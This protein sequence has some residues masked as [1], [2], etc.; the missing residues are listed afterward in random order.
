MKSPS[1]FST[2]STVAPIKYLVGC[3]LVIISFAST[4][5]FSQGK[6]AFVASEAIMEKL[7]DAKAART[8][9]SEV[10]LG[11]MRDI[12][13]QEAEIAKMR[14]D[15]QTNR[16]LWS[17]QEKRDAESK[18]AD[19]ESK[20]NA[21][22]LAKFGPRGEF[23]RQQSDIMGP[24]VEKIS[25]AIEEEARAQKYDF[26]WDKSSRGATMLYANPA[27]DITWDVLKRLGVE[28]SD[29]ITRIAVPTEGSSSTEDAMRN[30]GRRD[31]G[32][33]PSSDPS[34]DPEAIDPNKALKP[35]ETPVSPP[36]R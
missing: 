27:N 14:G 21:F 10:Q 16:L 7:G 5:A 22:R 2:I 13:R 6:T 29:S 12:E 35:V 3:T 30:R 4:A 33:D 17:T 36:K 15:I 24:V 20:L 18:L 19:L 31:R 11:W 34:A 9:L 26:V 32:T 8:K 28:V 25:K 23:E 1:K